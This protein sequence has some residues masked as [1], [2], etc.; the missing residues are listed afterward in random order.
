VCGVPLCWGCLKLLRRRCHPTRSMT[1]ARSKLSAISADQPPMGHK[2]DPELKEHDQQASG[3]ALH[4]SIQASVFSA[5]QL[6]LLPSPA[7]IS[8]RSA[9]ALIIAGTKAV[10][11]A[12]V[13]Q[14]AAAT[15]SEIV[16][17]D[18]ALHLVGPA[19]EGDSF[20]PWA[21]LAALLA[22]VFTVGLA[23]GMMVGS[24]AR[25]TTPSSPVMS[26]SKP[27][28]VDASVQTDSLQSLEDRLWR[29]TVP[30]LSALAVKVGINPGVGVAKPILV[31][32]LA[33]HDGI[34]E[35][36]VNE[37]LQSWTSTLRRGQGASTAGR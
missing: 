7:Q 14:T 11:V 22:F 19:T 37:V 34:N 20:L 1:I 21:M 15:K 17:Y 26:D 30:L 24:C 6:S 18:S 29:L 8:C 28:L 3:K 5:S 2:A 13:L 35:E 27:M 4:T 25:A 12:V 10:V 16:L 36:V 32:A 31:Y 33:R 23:T 9:N